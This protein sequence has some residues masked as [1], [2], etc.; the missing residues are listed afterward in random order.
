MHNESLRDITKSR[1]HARKWSLAEKKG[2][3]A[4]ESILHP[5]L[6]GDGSETQEGSCQANEAVGEV[7]EAEADLTSCQNVDGPDDV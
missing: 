1:V 5:T 6:E 2:S 7:G 4:K 3:L